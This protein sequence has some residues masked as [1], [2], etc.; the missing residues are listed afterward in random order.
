MLGLFSAKSDHPLADAKEAKR[1]FVDLS[2][3]DA[4]AALDDAAIL[5]ES[6]HRDHLVALERR[7][8]ILQQMDAAVL[9]V[10]QRFA[11]DYAA[12][13]HATRSEEVRQWRLGADYWQQLVTS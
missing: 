1:L 8:D 9:A 10:A 5:L 12:A 7:W 2:G 6:L 11:R 13:A 3:K 4:A